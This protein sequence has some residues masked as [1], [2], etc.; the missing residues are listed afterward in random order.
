MDISRIARR[1]H[2]AAVAAQKARALERLA[3]LAHER[4]SP[5]VS[6]TD[7]AIV[8]NL[9]KVQLKI[10]EPVAAVSH[11]KGCPV[12]RWF[13]DHGR[14]VPALTDEAWDRGEPV[15]HSRHVG[16]EIVPSHD[17]LDSFLIKAR[18]GILFRELPADRG[19]GTLYARWRRWLAAGTW[20]QVMTLLEG[21]PEDPPAGGRPGPRSGDDHG[22]HPRSRAEAP[23][24]GW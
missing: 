13:R 5:E 10:I 20:K 24:R 2:L 14:T 17:V 9:L 4:L 6:L 18:T 19:N 11:G 23:G 7:K 16:T 3:A 21:S 15:C 22:G 12:G 8:F 1:V